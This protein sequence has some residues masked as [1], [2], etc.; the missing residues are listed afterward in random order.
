LLLPVSSRLSIKRAIRT[1]LLTWFWGS[2]RSVFYWK[3]QSP[4]MSKHLFAIIIK[5]VPLRKDFDS[6]KN[7]C[8]KDLQVASLKKIFLIF[9]I[10]ALRIGPTSTII[11]DAVSWRNMC[12]ALF[13]LYL[14]LLNNVCLYH[15]KNLFKSSMSIEVFSFCY[16]FWLMIIIAKMRLLM[17]LLKSW[18]ALVFFF[19][20]DWFLYNGLLRPCWNRRIFLLLRL[21]VWLSIQI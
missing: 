2:T 3:F 19:S 20:I 13:I 4:A 16:R 9:G 17:I 7:T 10:I 11:N 18:F 1:I 21:R 5:R 12:V 8:T 6:V 15:W 14:F